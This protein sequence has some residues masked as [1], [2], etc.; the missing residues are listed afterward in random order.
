MTTQSDEGQGRLD[1]EKGR[2]SPSQKII[3]TKHKKRGR[4]SSSSDFLINSYGT[5]TH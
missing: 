2:H 3:K 4:I 1:D 5:H